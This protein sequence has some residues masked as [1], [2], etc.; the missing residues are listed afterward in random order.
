VPR[1]VDGPCL[2]N[3]VRGGKTPDLDLGEA[4]RM[5]YKLALV[6]GMLIQSFIATSEAVLA[7]LAA[8]RRH[9]KLAKEIAV[10]E[11]FRL[12]GANDWDAL[13]TKFR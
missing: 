6:P 12:M 11:I 1:L 13:R 2:L 4:E 3:V 5:G 8:I 7:E 9:P 10:G